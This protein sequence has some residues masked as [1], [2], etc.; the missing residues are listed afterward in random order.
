MKHAET[1]YLRGLAKK[2]ISPVSTRVTDLVIR[3]AKGVRFWTADGSEYIDFVSG[4]ASN[5]LGHAHESMVKAIQE[6]AEDLIHFGLNYGYYESVV[7]LSE[8]IAQIAP[9]NLETVF[10]SNSGGE[11]IDGA[12]KM[13][14]AVTGRPGIIA[15][16]GSFHG[17]TLGATSV[18]GS[19]SKYRTSYEPLLGEVYHATYPYPGLLKGDVPKDMTSYSL[20]QIESLFELRISP[21]RVAAILIEPVMGEGGYYPAPIEFLQGLREIADKHGILLIFD[22]VQTGFGRTGKMFASE[23][24]GVVPD[25]LVLAKALSGGMPLG[26]IVAS[27]ALHEKWPTGAHGSTFGGNPVSCA[28][29]LA[30]IDV[31]ET[32]N[33]VKRSEWLGK[34][35]V[36]RLKAN[37]QKYRDIKEI[38]GVGMMIGIEFQPD[39]ASRIVPAIKEKCLERH[40]LIMSCGVNGQTIRLMLPLNIIEEDMEE[41]LTILESAIGELM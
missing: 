13:A 33:L 27:R 24:S 28:A 4:V 7:K 29:A 31:I 19:S 8:K 20:S 37:L 25:I 1:E 15:F 36:N 17:R 5:G 38:R 34:K 16:D 2:H 39:V 11:A 9:G 21:E 23:H 30:S 26:A 10:F 3:R 14:R 18:T 12:I 35:I 32:E 41:G 40:L 6:Q 22:E